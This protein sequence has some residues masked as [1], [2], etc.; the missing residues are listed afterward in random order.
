MEINRQLKCSYGEKR[1][2]LPLKLDYEESMRDLLR[3]NPIETLHTD[4]S[5]SALKDIKQLQPNSLHLSTVQSSD[6]INSHQA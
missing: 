3:N 2:D 6:D 4:A 1:A 5:P